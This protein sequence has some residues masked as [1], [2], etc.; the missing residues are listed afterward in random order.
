MSIDTIEVDDTVE[1]VM[2]CKYGYV[3]DRGVVSRVF[4]NGNIEVIWQGKKYR[5]QAGDARMLSKGIY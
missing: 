1:F 4:K 5:V 2:E 3:Q